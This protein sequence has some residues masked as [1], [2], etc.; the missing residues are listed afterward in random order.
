MFSERLLKEF[1]AQI[2][3]EFAS[4]NYYLAMAAYCKDLDLDGFANFFIVQAEEERFHAMKFFNFVNELGARVIMS[5]YEDPKN[6]FKNLEDIFQ[7]ALDHERFVT[8]RINLLMS[9][10]IEDKNYACVSYLNWFVDEQV[11]EMANMTTLLNKVKRIGENGHAI[12]VL[13]SELAT[14]VFTPP[15]A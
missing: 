9:I 3:H 15:V 2:K 7:S 4:A 13:D 8:D 10:A 11:E 12:Y 6:D 1:N 5:G 14:R